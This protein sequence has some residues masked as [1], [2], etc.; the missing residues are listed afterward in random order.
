MRTK[1]TLILLAA[2]GAWT[3]W[4]PA[5]R[6]QDGL[7]SE[8]TQYKFLPRLSF[9]HVSGGES[10][11]FPLFN[12]VGT[13]DFTTTVA[14]MDVHPPVII[15]DFENVQAGA[16]ILFQNFAIPLDKALNLSGLTGTTR[17]TGT[18]KVFQFTGKTDDSSVEL[19]AATLG[20]G[21]TCAGKRRR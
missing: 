3:A 12:V 1:H 10:P 20:R 19:W 9:L 21:C 4:S 6:A 15:G 7:P 14:P 16:Q 17:M 5:G 11:I 18:I 8:T 2:L 13:Y